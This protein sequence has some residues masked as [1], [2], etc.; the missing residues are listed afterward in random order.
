MTKRQM[1]AYAAQ[2]S[3]MTPKTPMTVAIVTNIDMQNV[4]LVLSSRR[5]MNGTDMTPPRGRATSKKLLIS[6]AFE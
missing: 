3:G 5:P 1:F 6:A 4:V 2:A